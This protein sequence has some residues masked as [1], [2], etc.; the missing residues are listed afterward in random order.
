MIKYP[1]IG[2]YWIK[3]KYENILYKSASNNLN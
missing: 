1:I 3:W 2:V